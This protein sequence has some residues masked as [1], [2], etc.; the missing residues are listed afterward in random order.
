VFTALMKHWPAERPRFLCAKG[1]EQTSGL[2]PG[3]YHQDF[4]R[5]GR[6]IFFFKDPE[7]GLWWWGGGGGGG[8]RGGFLLVFF[9]FFFFFL[10]PKLCSQIYVAGKP[11]GGLTLAADQ[12]RGAGRF[13]CCRMLGKP[14]AFRSL[15]GR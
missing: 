7:G 2:L 5:K 9:F 11:T 6:E 4:W 3:W 13:R 1:I 8:P 15:C 12:T 10:G 14:A